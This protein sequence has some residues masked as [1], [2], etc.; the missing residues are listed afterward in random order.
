MFK[1]TTQI[2][3]SFHDMIADSAAS[4]LYHEQ[5]ES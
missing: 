4:S 1:P 3:D 2:L 5:R